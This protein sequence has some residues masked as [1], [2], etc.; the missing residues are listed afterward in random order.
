[1]LKNRLSNFKLALSQLPGVTYCIIL[2][3]VQVSGLVSGV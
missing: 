2:I 3:L 1:M